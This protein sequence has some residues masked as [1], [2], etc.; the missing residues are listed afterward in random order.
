MNW[1]MFG[2]L[3][4]Y[5]GAAARRE[6]AALHALQQQLKPATPLRRP[7]LRFVKRVFD[8][9]TVSNVKRFGNRPLA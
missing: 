3:M 8:P 7:A 5:M 2:F 4:G 6:Q 9:S 1:T